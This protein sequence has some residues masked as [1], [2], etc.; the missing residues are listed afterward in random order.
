MDVKN[1]NS[2]TWLQNSV[3]IIYEL[4]SD[5]EYSEFHDFLKKH[6]RSFPI[7]DSVYYY[8]P[9]VVSTPQNHI[10]DLFAKLV[11]CIAPQDGLCLISGGIPLK[12]QNFPEIEK[13]IAKNNECNVPI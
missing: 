2:I 7:G 10:D 6:P 11:E 9:I 5:R 13:L 3:T 8:D 12:A 1:L 4:K